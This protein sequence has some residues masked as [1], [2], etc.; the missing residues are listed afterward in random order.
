MSAAAVAE[1]IEVPKV[2]EDAKMPDAPTET[3]TEEEKKQRAVR[4]SASKIQSSSPAWIPFR[5][6]R[7]LT[8]LAGCG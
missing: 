4:Q 1:P 5:V 3:E 2:E 7:V 6:A 8:D